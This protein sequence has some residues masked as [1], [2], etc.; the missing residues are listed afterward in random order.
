MV[1]SDGHLKEICVNYAVVVRQELVWRV[2]TEATG[3][4]GKN[5]QAEFPWG[6]L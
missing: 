5:P 1:G 4:S 6:L 3:S 2:S